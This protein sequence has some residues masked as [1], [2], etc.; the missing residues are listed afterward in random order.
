[1]ADA[2]EARRLYPGCHDLPAT[3]CEDAPLG[4]KTDAD[5]LARR[6]TLA[7]A[8]WKPGIY[9]ACQAAGM[10]PPD[11]PDLPCVFASEHRNGFARAALRAAAHEAAQGPGHE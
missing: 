4:L 11:V 1:M 2:E 7:L 10:Y 5:D 8:D 9:C 3:T 6:V